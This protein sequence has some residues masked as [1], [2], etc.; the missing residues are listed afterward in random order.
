LRQNSGAEAANP[1]AAAIRRRLRLAVVVAGTLLIP[2]TGAKKL[3]AV[4]GN[5]TL[6][7][8]YNDWKKYL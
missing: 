3:A 8:G 1:E 2:V 5:F 4:V 6:D 7:G